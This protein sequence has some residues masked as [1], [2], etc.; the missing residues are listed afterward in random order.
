MTSHK[1]LALGAI[2]P[3]GNE[4]DNATGLAVD[5][6]AAGASKDDTSFWQALCQL[7]LAESPLVMGAKL[8]SHGEVRR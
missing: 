3:S 1:A 2:G 8:K 5:A 6:V 4:R 7:I